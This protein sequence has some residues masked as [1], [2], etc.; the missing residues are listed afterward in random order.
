MSDKLLRFKLTLNFLTKIYVII[1][2]QRE[3][4]LCVWI[5]FFFG[6]NGIG[7][8]ENIKYRNNFKFFKNLRNGYLYIAVYY[9]IIN[10]FNYKIKIFLDTIKLSYIY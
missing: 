2:E 4:K 8:Y 3:E 1:I 5:K 10:I 9:K 7:L 6:K